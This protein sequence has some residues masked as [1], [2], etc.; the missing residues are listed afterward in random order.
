[1]PAEYSKDRLEQGV[2]GKYYQRSIEGIKQESES[3]RKFKK[4][5]TSAET[6]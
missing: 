6:E 4:T 3:H 5:K 2:R 1:M